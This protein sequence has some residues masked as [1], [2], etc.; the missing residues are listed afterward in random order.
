[1]KFELCAQGNLEISGHAKEHGKGFL[2]FAI[3]NVLYTLPKFIPKLPLD[4]NS[5]I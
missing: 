2:C 3:S 4:P 1:M 5:L